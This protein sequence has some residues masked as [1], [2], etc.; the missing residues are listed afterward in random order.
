MICRF[1]IEHLSRISRM[2]KQPRSHA[3]L[4]GVGGSGR[5]SLTRLSSHICDYDV[6][7]VEISKQYS[8]H[9][10]HEDIKLILKKTTATELHSTFLFTDS[11]IK[12]ESFLEDINNMLNSGEVFVKFYKNIIFSLIQIPFKLFSFRFLIFSVLMKKLRSVKKCAKLIDKEKD[13]C[14]QM[15]VPLLSLICLFN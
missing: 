15:E 7:Q 14:K 6:Y 8:M 11:Q 12:E 2:I 5:Q 10:W 13:R 3:L 9:E 4:V 1:A